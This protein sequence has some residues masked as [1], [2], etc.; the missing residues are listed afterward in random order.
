MANGLPVLVSNRC[1]CAPDLVL[2]GRNGY[3]FDPFDV[4]AIAEAMSRMAGSSSDQLN[5]M[6]QESRRIIAN[7][8]PD[9]FGRALQAAAEGAVR[10]G[11][12]R[13]TW[14]N[15]LLLRLLMTR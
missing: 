7:W 11:A 12:R 14:V 6:G 8:G 1:G 13:A 10:V 3:T 4:Q 15:R 5:L 9:R 2:E